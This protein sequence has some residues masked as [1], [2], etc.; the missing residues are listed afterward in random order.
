MFLQDKLF[1]LPC[2]L[3]SLVVASPSGTVARSSLNFQVCTKYFSF[4]SLW[5]LNFAGIEYTFDVDIL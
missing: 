2:K 1:W 4:I 3:G 5:E